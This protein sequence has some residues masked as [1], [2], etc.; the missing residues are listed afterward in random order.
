MFCDRVLCVC[1]RM[2]IYLDMNRY[3]QYITLH[4]I[5]LHCITLH[6][7]ALRCIALHHITFHYFTLQGNPF[8]FLFHS[9]TSQT[10]THTDTHA[11][12]VIVD[13]VHIYT[14]SISYTQQQPPRG[15]EAVFVMGL[16]NY[17]CIPSQH[18]AAPAKVSI[19]LAVDHV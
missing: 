15:Q 10:H 14:K 7:V 5:T 18:G 11:Y 13:H 17:F 9:I 6:C 16:L 4:C 1:V 8:H 3:V 12:V 19:G 2:W